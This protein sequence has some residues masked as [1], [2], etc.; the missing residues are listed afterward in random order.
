MGRLGRR[1][2]QTVSVFLNQLYS[3]C[4]LIPN[5]VADDERIVRAIY[6]P[7]H[8]DQKLTRLR[9]S[10][11]EPPPG[12]DELSVM[13]LEYLGARASK[14]H[15]RRIENPQKNRTYRGFAVLRVSRIRATNMSVED[16]RQEFCGHADIRLLLDALKNRQA[17]EPLSATDGKRLKELKD[18][19]LASSK[20]VADPKPRSSRWTAGLLDPP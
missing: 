14:R 12:T 17:K 4:W 10:A 3:L 13:R 8:L 19:L 6:S 16:S 11:Y 7:V 9:P 1:F 2:L 15:A 20:Y 18:Y 5:H